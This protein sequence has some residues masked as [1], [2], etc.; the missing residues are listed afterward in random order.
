VI[1][2]NTVTIFW[3]ICSRWGWDKSHRSGRRNNV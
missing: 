1:Y 3:S 2:N